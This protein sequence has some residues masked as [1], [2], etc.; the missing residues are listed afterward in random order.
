[1]NLKTLQKTPSW[2]W[3]ENAEEKLLEVLRNQDARKPDRVLAAE[4]A[5]EYT[6]ISDQLCDALLAIV[7]SG[8]EPEDLRASA[9]ISLGPA[10]ES[11]DT[12]DFEDE[13]D[14]VI[15]EGMF[16]KIQQA[17]RDLFSDSSVPQEVRRRIL[18]ASVRAPEPWH[19]DAVRAA[20]ASND[21][22]WRL[23]AVFGMRYIRGFDNQ[24]LEALE[25]D[26]PDIRCEAVTAAG[27]SELDAAWPHIAA[28]IAAK[29]TDKDLLLAA[30]EAAALIR[31]E[32]AS[33]IL[34]DHL[35]SGDEDIREAAFEAIEM[36]EAYQ[37]S[38]SEEEGEEEEE[39]D[40]EDEDF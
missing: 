23:T 35:D 11:A 9:A 15:S 1:M 2:E 12:A 14:D 29:G 4:L 40:E 39:E 7:G 16:H 3:P 24:I 13:Y 31:P 34:G 30:I 20:Y 37:K 25:S 33:E 18:E 6:V 8:K 21:Q 32:E 28:L 38:E 17:L 27:E 5:G 10:L 19:A 26:D 36:A 22:T